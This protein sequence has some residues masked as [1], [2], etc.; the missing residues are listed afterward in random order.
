MMDFLKKY[1][2]VYMYLIFGVLT[3]VISWGTYAILVNWGWHMIVANLLSWLFAIIVAFITNKLWVFCSPS[4]QFSVLLREIVTFLSSRI[5]TGVVEIVLVPVVVALGFD[6]LMLDLVHTIGLQGAFFETEGIF[7][8]A[9]I[10]VVVVILNYFFSKFMV[11]VR[12]KEGT[13]DRVHQ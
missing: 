4:W 3:T 10:T 1:K 7:S 5:F 11:F 13:N 12:K 9:L 8:K 6:S 2:E